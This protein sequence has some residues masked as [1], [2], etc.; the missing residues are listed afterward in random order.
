VRKVLLDTS[1]YAALLGGDEAVLDAIAEASQV[2]MSIFVLG[3]LLA[4]FLGGRRER[5]NRE[6]LE[7]FLGK[8]TVIVIDATRDTAD[9]FG[10]I[11][12]RLRRA[13]TPIPINDV[14]IAAHANEHGAET[15]T[16][17]RHFTFIPGLLL[18]AGVSGDRGKA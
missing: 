8:P 7:A 1:A 5:E 15:I 14:W 12:D 6:R 16:Y 4:G 9:I 3:E 2:F 10:R 11:K 18:W 17:D 13:G